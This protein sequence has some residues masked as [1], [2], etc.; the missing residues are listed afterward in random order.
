[1]PQRR[2]IPYRPTC[3]AVR[4]FRQVP[5]VFDDARTEQRGSAPSSGAHRYP[6]SHQLTFPTRRTVA[7][8][9][10]GD[11][12]DGRSIGQG[13]QPGCADAAG[14]VAPRRLLAGGQLSVGGANLPV[15]QSF[16]QGA[17]GQGAY[18]AAPARP[19]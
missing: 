18:Q 15:R 10:Y 9:W 6:Q 19:L 14:P 3:T 13:T 12:D 17:F 16:A 7:Q 5:E 2:G 4:P 8:Y 11:P 1:M